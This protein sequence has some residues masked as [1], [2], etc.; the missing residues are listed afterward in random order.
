M[1]YP[2]RDVLIAELH[3]RGF[4]ASRCHLET[5]AFRTSANLQEIVTVCVGGIGIAPRPASDLCK[6]LNLN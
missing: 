6:S 3:S 2:P 1:S 5:K 4:A